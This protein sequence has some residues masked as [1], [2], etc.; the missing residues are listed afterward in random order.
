MAFSFRTYA[1]SKVRGRATATGR[2]LAACGRDEAGATAVE[3]ALVGPVLFLLLMGCIE[4]GIVYAANMLLK[5]SVYTAARSG[6]TGFVPAKTTQTAAIR[7]IV[8]NE[9]G[10]LM[11]ASK[12]TIEA[13]SYTGFDT[14][15]KPEPFVDKNKNGKRDEG[16]TF[17][18]V[19]G[20]GKYDTD[21]GAT[22]YGGT[23]EVVL[24]TVTYP[25]TF[26]TPLLGRIMAPNGALTLSATAVVQNEP[27]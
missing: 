18:D 26:F 19:N 7:T 8:Q 10:I 15:G 2:R 14:L 1:G 25:W 17:T 20:N 23:N 24:Y 21:Q 13:K 16:E 11:D 5:H 6:R 4:L 27:Y 3:F 9:A 22:G 12:L